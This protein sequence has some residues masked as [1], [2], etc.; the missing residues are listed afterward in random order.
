MTNLKFTR[1]WP[2]ALLLM[3]SVLLMTAS[4]QEPDGTRELKSFFQV[5]VRQG[6]S[7][8]LVA[9]GVLTLNVNAETG[10]FTGTLTP[11]VGKDTG[12]PL[13]SVLFKQ[14]ADSFTPEPAGVTELAV[15]G[16]M[17]GHAINLMLLDVR[18]VGKD[19]VGVGTMENTLAEQ[20]Q[21]KG[22]GVVA[23]PAVGPEDGDSGDWAG[24][25]CALH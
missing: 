7:A 20:L 6:S 1:S 18:G 10:N 3:G 5:T 9:Y 11:A 13:S 16:T 12:E 17:H 25:C 14:T 24:P 2:L 19:I 4:A 8:G 21:G 23:G 15:R 22:H